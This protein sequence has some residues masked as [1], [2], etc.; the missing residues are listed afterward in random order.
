MSTPAAELCPVV[1]RTLAGCNFAVRRG[2][3]AGRTQVVYHWA[4]GVPFK[5]ICEL[6][7]VLEGAIVRTIVRLDETCRCA[8]LALLC[9]SFMFAW[10]L[11]LCVVGHTLLLCATKNAPPRQTPTR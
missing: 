4:K 11:M 10:V 7:D 2:P 9:S 1:P 5:D 6:T 3:V 8:K